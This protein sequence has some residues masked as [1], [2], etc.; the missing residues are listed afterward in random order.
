MFV[1][2][3]H[4][5]IVLLLSVSFSNITPNIEA[6]TNDASNTFEDPKTGITFQYP[7][8]WQVASQEYTDRVFGTSDGSGSTTDAIVSLLPESVNGAAFDILSEILPFPM[9]VE[10]Y[11]E[12]GKSQ[13]LSDPTAEVSNA[14]PISIAGTNGLKYNI[15]FSDPEY[16]GFLQTQIAFIKDSTAFIIMYNLGHNDQ[17]KD[18]AS[19]NSVTNSLTFKGTTNGSD[20]DSGDGDSGDGDSGDGDSGDGDSG[21]GDSGDGDGDEGEMVET[22]VSV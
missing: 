3:S 7:S 8:D 16:Q 21:D 4:I 14:V 19:I 15:T 20:G 12:M 13:I 6:Q 2:A 1:K 17:S 5:I 9:S 11:Y 10:K 18:M 22:K